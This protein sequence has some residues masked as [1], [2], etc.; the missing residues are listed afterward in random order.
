MLFA[1]EFWGGSSNIEGFDGDDEA[2]MF[3]TIADGVS[4]V[5]ACHPFTKIPQKLLEKK[6]F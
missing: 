5:R 2:V 6:M 3:T 1:D 4:F